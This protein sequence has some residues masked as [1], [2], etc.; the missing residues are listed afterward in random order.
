M[1]VDLNHVTLSGSLTQDPVLGTLPSGKVVCEMR[2]ACAY[3]SREETTGAWRDWTDQ[4]PV[5]AFGYQARTAADHLRK[6]RRVAIVGRDPVQEGGG[7][8]RVRRVCG[9]KRSAGR[10]RGRD[11]V[12]AVGSLEPARPALPPG[13]A[14]GGRRWSD[15]AAASAPDRNPAAWAARMRERTLRHGPGP[16]NSSS[17]SPS[18][19]E[20]YQ[21]F[22]RSRRDDQRRSCSPMRFATRHA[23]T[24]ARSPRAASSS[25]SPATRRCGPS[26]VVYRRISIFARS[27]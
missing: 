19:G 23:T 4:V 9:P 1:S 20:S 17:V 11:R 7:R 21:V 15:H 5:R 10:P 16:T 22:L 14:V 6:G 25:A 2:V 24:P 13:R 3:R 27:I 8:E 12:R 26:R 18:T